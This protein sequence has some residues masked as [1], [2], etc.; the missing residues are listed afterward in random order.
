MNVAGYLAGSS[1]VYLVGAHKKCRRPIHQTP[2]PK[3]ADTASHH[4]VERRLLLPKEPPRF[5]DRRSDF[6]HDFVQAAS[7]RLP[8]GQIHHEG[9]HQTPNP[10]RDGPAP[11]VDYSPDPPPPVECDT[12]SASC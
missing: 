11:A 3:R 12:G 4:D 8:N 1:D 2:A 9:D 10:E 6:I 5:F 7:G